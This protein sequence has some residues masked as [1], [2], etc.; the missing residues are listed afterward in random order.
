MSGWTDV[1]REAGK[2]GRK[3]SG[4][5]NRLIKKA[6]LWLIV[7][8]YCLLAMLLINLTNVT[9]SSGVTI[10][11]LL[12]LY[13]ILLHILCFQRTTEREGYIIYPTI[14]ATLLAFIYF[15]YFFFL[16]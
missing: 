7:I 5:K 9:L 6:L 13:N 8:D 4:V 12:V 16:V 1:G 14:T 3:E 2:K 10:S 15:L 11:L